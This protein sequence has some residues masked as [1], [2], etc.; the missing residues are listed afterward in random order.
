MPFPLFRIGLPILLVASA[1]TSIAQSTPQPPRRVAASAPSS[2]PT[3]RSAYRSAFAGYRAFSEQSLTPWRQA[4]DA[5][6]QIGGWQAYAREG[7]GK[8]PDAPSAPGKQTMQGMDMPGMRM[9]A[10]ASTGAAA[11]SP[12]SAPPVRK[13]P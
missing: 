9:P 13:A 6:G 7:Q 1:A 8:E 4:N 2:D 3:A 10:A 5:V 12:A 11:S